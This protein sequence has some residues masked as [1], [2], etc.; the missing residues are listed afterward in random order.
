MVPA[1]RRSFHWT[2]VIAD[3][4]NPLLGADFIHHFELIVDG[5]NC[6]LVDSATKCY[7]SARSVSNQILNISINEFSVAT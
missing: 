4:V 6:R 3:T 1:L 2:F 5:K 7:C